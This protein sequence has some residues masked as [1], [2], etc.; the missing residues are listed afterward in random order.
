MKTVIYPSFPI[1]IAK[2]LYGGKPIYP[3]HA[4]CLKIT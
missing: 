2:A 4:I 3:V 1:Y